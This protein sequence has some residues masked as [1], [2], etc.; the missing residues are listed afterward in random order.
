MMQR[1]RALLGLDRTVT[2]AA[3]IWLER[4]TYQGGWERQYPNTAFDGV[5]ARPETDDNKWLLGPGRYRLV[6]RTDGRYGAILWEYETA[7]ADA[8]YAERREDAH[9][10]RQREELE[11]MS[12]DEV[13]AELYGETN[14]L[15]LLADWEIRERFLAL[16]AET[17]ATSEPPANQNVTTEDLQARFAVQAL[18]SDA[19]IEQ[20]GE[21]IA[22]DA[23]LNSSSDNRAGKHQ[24]VGPFPE[25][26][27]EI[28]HDPEQLEEVGHYAGQGV[29]AALNEFSNGG[30][31]SG[32]T[33][34][35]FEGES[36]QNKD[37][38]G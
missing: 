21:S 32:P 8:Q 2:Q 20:Y 10:N 27:N 4:Q 14:E 1:L 35:T 36:E 38:N 6:T 22:L 31:D 12:L 9:R 26:V 5:P 28:A 19:F 34:F 18:N 33:R 3:D 25:L 29:R 7:D 24:D 16:Q 13:K 23:V 11:T 15:D 17:T 30:K 37:S